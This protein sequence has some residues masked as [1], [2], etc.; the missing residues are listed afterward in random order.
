MAY[1]EEEK[2]KAFKIV[3]D[4][5]ANGESLRAVLRDENTMGSESFYKWMEQDESKAKQYAHAY[6]VRA[7]VIFEEI[8]EIADKQGSDV[9]IVDGKEV[10]NNNVVQR[11]RL[12]VDA[13]KWV[14]AKMNPKKYSDKIQVDSSVFEEQPLFPDV[15]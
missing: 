6:S 8:L 14:L 1:T 5:V 15:K 3:T 4:R 11:S 10:T 2:T 9:D 12:Q 13:R 7:D